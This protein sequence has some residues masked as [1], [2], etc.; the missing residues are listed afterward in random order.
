MTELTVKEDVVFKVFF[1][2]S[3]PPNIIYQQFMKKST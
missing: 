2:R 3:A 1:K